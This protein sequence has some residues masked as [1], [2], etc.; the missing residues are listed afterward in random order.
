MDWYRMEQHRMKLDEW[1]GHRVERMKWNMIVKNKIRRKWIDGTEIVDT[2][3]IR[4]NGIGRYR[5]QERPEDDEMV[6]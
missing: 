6:K 3:R 5:R 2:N 4:W 1:N